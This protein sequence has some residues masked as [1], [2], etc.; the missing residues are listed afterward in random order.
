MPSYRAHPLAQDI[1]PGIAVGKAYVFEVS[2]LLV[3]EGIASEVRSFVSR[4]L[5]D[6]H[7]SLHCVYALRPSRRLRP[8]YDGT[9]VHSPAVTTRSLFHLTPLLFT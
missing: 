7:S 5:C 9:G 4:F 6:S 1:A 8:R 2:L 3:D